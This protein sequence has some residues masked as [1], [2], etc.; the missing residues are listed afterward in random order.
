MVSAANESLFSL[1]TQLK[2]LSFLTMT[3]G[4]MF[5]PSFVQFIGCVRCLSLPQTPVW[6][7][8]LLLVH[9]EHKEVKSTG[10]HPKCREMCR[11]LRIP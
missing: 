11:F 5:A 1:S 10:W 8:A 2:Q 4:L 3:L 7:I 9:K 6:P